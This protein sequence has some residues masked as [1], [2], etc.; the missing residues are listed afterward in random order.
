MAWG[1]WFLQPHCGNSGEH[2]SHQGPAHSWARSN[3]ILCFGPLHHRWVPRPGPSQYLVLPRGLRTLRTTATS[4]NQLPE[5]NIA[6]ITTASGISGKINWLSGL[7][8]LLSIHSTHWSNRT[9][10]TEFEVNDLC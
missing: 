3:N 1:C 7:P 4:F 10:H 9:S 8:A 2:P 6:S 5:F